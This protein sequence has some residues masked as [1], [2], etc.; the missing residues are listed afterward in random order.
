MT[1]RWGILL[2]AILLIAGWEAVATG[3]DPSGVILIGEGA[4]P[5][6][7]YAARELQRYLYQLSGHLPAI[8]R[9]KPEAALAGPVFLIGRPADHPLLARLAAEG[10]IKVSP[11]DPGPQGYVLKIV[12]AGG[13][14][15]LAIVGGDEVGCLYGVYGLL[16]DHY[17]VGFYLGGDVLPQRKTT[18]AL[19]KVDERKTPAVA[20]RGFLP[21]T[22]FPQ[23]ATSYSW[24]DWRF[25]I[26]QMAKMRMNFLHIHNYNGD[27]LHNEMFHNF[28]LHG[29]TSRVWMATARTG[30][31]WSMPGW[32]VSKYRFG[33]GDLFDDYDYG[34][35]CA[36]HNETLSNVEVFRKGASLFQ[37]VIAYAHTR[38]VKIGLG[39]DLN[40]KM[41]D[42]KEA[43]DDP[44]LIAARVKQI[45][46]DYPDL[47]YLLC[48]QSEGMGAEA[49][50][51]WQRIFDGFYT[52]MKARSPRTALAVAGWGLVPTSIAK[53]PPDVI[54]GPISAYS[55]GCESG[56]IY[57]TREFWGCPWLERDF[58]S[59]EYYYPYNMHLFN[60]VKAWQQRAG[61]MNGFYCLSWR[62]TD[63]VEPKM[64]FLAKAPWDKAGRYATARAVYR[65]YAE[66]NYGP[67]AADAIAAILDNN[68]PY[69]TDHG[70]CCGTPQFFSPPMFNGKPS[71]DYLFNFRDFTLRG[72]EGAKS[73]P[74]AAFN[75]PRPIANMPCGDGKVCVVYIGPGTWLRYDNVDFGQGMTDFEA[76]VASPIGGG[77][78]EIR[79]DGPDGELLGKCDVGHSG[80]WQKWATFK[81]T[82]RKT[83]GKHALCLRMVSYP[84]AGDYDK[85]AAQLAVIDKCIQAAPLPIYRARLAV[86]RCRI[87]AAK[88]HIEMNRDFDNYAWKDL[89]GPM[90]SWVANFT[91]RV[92]DVSSLGNVV[93]IENRYVQLNYERKEKQLR[94]A[95][96]IQ[97]PSGVTARGTRQGAMIAWSNE[98]PGAKGFY[99]YRDDTRLTAEPLPPTAESSADSY[100]GAARYTVT[101]VGPDGKESVHSEP[102]F[103]AAG[104][105]D[106]TPPHIVVIS[107]PVSV[108][109][110]QPVW[111]KARCLDNRTYESI[112]ARLHYR[113]PGAG[114]WRVVPMKRR[115]KAVFTVEIP[116]HEIT[117]AGLEYYVEA[118]DGDNLAV[119][120][121][122][123]W[124]LTGWTQTPLSLVVWPAQP[125][126][127]AAPGD[128]RAEGDALAWSA[129][130]GEVFWYRIYRSQ[131]PD[132][133]PGPDNFLT[134]VEKATTRFRDASE[135]FA[136]R[137]RAGVWYYRVTAVSKDDF[138]GPPTAAVKD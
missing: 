99:V 136:G 22:N 61:N 110:G 127:P 45:A 124:P 10:K 87:A 118:D 107:P 38:G 21:W 133:T 91:H 8:E 55:D 42:Y 29:V 18:L 89:P 56:S 3:A 43:V 37:K 68:E 32:D 98:Q 138:E 39:V 113:T 7:Q 2:A 130:A 70:E 36:L 88:D 123:P 101:V 9:A 115:V 83:A 63:A 53:L 17:G 132:F 12:P 129:P 84:S 125:H 76:V 16:E 122:A 4:P 128:F 24:Q 81:T 104:T 48:F 100:S 137:K 73:M 60:T 26:D 117:A 108:A 44:E 126:A 74:A 131:Q 80:D 90:P 6:E 5:M 69:V 109:E 97:P 11:G 93:S 65:D 112:S 85:A 77:V 1:R 51:V 105:A 59:S 78:I 28:T 106:K 40:L 50:Q 25:I 57:G 96:S 102:A 134:Y 135:D 35:D 47:D 71:G 92:T 41:P 20:I 75:N 58:G 114:E 120:P 31:H 79:L 86:L 23:S 64:S 121:N 95:F 46:G 66:R 67:A 62:L 116:A 33:A 111:I 13:S 19:V 119:Y 54:C 82:I 14:E 15:A 27:N 72:P 94:K 49:Y 52:G 34:A 103:C 30:H